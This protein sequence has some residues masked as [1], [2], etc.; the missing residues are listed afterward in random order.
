MRVRERVTGREY[1][2]PYDKLILAQGG[3]PILPPIPGG[4]AGHVFRLWTVPVA[5][6]WPAPA[7]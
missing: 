4:D 1:D 7:P 6:A 3:N 5:T 2:E